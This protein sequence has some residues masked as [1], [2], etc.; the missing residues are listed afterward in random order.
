MGPLPSYPPVP[1]PHF[2]FSATT[3]YYIERH[4]PTRDITYHTNPAEFM[5]H[6]VIG[7]ELVRDGVDLKVEYQKAKESKDSKEKEKKVKRGPNMV[8]FGAGV[9]RTHVTGVYTQCRRGHGIHPGGAYHPPNSGS[10]HSE[11]FV[12][13]SEGMGP[14][15]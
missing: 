13:L 6:P 7:P 11:A 14:S 4:T 5:N 15:Y 2:S 3:R 1:D 10:A 9:E 12:R 8:K